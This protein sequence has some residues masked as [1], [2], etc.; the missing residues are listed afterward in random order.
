MIFDK[1]RN[2]CAYGAVDAETRQ[3]VLLLHSTIL[4]ILSVEPDDPD[5]VSYNLTCRVEGMNKKLIIKGAPR[6]TFSVLEGEE[7]SIWDDDVVPT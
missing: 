7:Q 6:S 2:K 5:Q 4:I 3:S 1:I